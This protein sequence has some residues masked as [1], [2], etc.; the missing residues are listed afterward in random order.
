MMDKVVTGGAV[1]GGTVT[2]RVPARRD[3]V[4]GG[5]VTGSVSCH[6][7]GKRSN[8]HM[9]PIIQPFNHPFTHSSQPAEILPYVRR[10]SQLFSFNP[11]FFPCK[12]GN[13]KGL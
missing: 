12:R 7:A 8:S 1:A 13:T 10:E 3:E 2:G 9:H 5:M 11:L 4:A 6:S